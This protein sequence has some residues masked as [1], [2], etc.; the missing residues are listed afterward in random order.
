MD[1]FIVGVDGVDVFLETD[2]LVGVAVF[3]F[4]WFDHIFDDVVELAE[5]DDTIVKAFYF[6]YEIFDV[7]FDPSQDGSY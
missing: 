2:F 4:M 5:S 7:L 1:A 3:C 6:A